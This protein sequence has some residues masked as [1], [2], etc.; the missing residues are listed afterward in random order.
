MSLPPF[1]LASSRVDA[2]ELS[3]LEPLPSSGSRVTLEPPTQE[4]ATVDLSTVRVDVGE[5]THDA[6]VEPPTARG[7]SG[8]SEYETLVAPDAPAPFRTTPP[9]APRIRAITEPG[10]RKRKHSLPV[11]TRAIEAAYQR[12]LHRASDQGGKAA[13]L[14]AMKNGLSLEVLAIELVTSE[15]YRLRCE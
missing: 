15:E 9:Q 1:T 14:E 8:T 2:G 13:Y 12:Y 3:T 6:L 7:V 11:R 10:R 4:P 5:E